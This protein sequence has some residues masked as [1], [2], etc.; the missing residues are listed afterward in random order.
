MSNDAESILNIDGEEDLFS[1]SGVSESPTKAAVKTPVETPV[2]TPAELQ[3]ESTDDTDTTMPKLRGDDFPQEYL[4]LVNRV[5][6]QYS[7]LPKLDYRGLYAELSDLSIQSTPT[8]TLQ[9]INAELSKVQAFKD[10]LAEIYVDVLQCHN[11]KKRAVDIL[12]DGWGRYANEKSADRRKGDATFR[13]SDFEMDF[14]ETE[15]LLKAC[16]HVIKNLDSLHD[17]L[18]RRITIRQIQLKL[19]N[20]RTGLPDFDFDP[21]DDPLNKEPVNPSEGIEPEEKSFDSL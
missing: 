7:F 12:K 16:N 17:N 11:I 13:L 6:T 2:E 19:G 9:T 10:R 20:T 8:P 15:A 14:A 1:D 3:R 4:D 18:S 5:R 21:D